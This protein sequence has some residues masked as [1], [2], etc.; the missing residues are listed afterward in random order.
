MDG[1]KKALGRLHELGIK[2]V[3]I[4]KHNFLVWDGGRDERPQEQPGGHEFPGRSRA[5]L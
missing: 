5:R 1:C 3:D 2:L 4:N